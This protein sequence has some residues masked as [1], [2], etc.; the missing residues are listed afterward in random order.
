MLKS[1][2]PFLQ[3]LERQQRIDEQEKTNVNLPR[4]TEQRLLEEKLKEEGFEIHDIVPDGNCLFSAVS[5]QLKRHG[6]NLTASEL[7]KVCAKNLRE[8]RS[9]YEAFIVDVDFESYCDRIEQDQACW[10]GQIELQALSKELQCRVVV[11][12]ADGPNIVFGTDSLKKTVLLSFHRHLIKLGEHYNSV[13]EISASN[14]S[15]ADSD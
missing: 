1:I 15:D 7:R 3:S 12:Q 6:Q 8:N 5:H 9:D 14:D 13:V 10:G 2:S 11:Y 4:A